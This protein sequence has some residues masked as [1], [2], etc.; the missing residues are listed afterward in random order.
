MAMNVLHPKVT[1][2]EH[3]SL[4]RLLQVAA[5][6]T[7]K[8]AASQIFCSPGSNAA[9]AT[10]GLELSEKVTPTSVTVKRSGVHF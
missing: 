8:A 9:M 4:K 3:E 10:R 5:G 2:R 7:G 6:D 1:E